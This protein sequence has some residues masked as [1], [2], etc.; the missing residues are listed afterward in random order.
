MNSFFLSYSNFLKF[1][2]LLRYAQQF[3]SI[4]KLLIFPVF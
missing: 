4:S 2:P 3:A 1:G